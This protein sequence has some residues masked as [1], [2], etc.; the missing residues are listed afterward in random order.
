M[1]RQGTYEVAVDIEVGRSN[2]KRV[3]T[4]GK[5]ARREAARCV[6]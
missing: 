2:Y 1:L 4:R 3:A 5:R 6:T